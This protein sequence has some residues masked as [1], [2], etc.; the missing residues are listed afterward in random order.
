MGLPIQLKSLGYLNEIF[1]P[2]ETKDWKVFEYR[3]SSKSTVS[4]QGQGVEENK[5]KIKEAFLSWY[6]PCGYMSEAMDKKD[7]NNNFVLV[8]DRWLSCD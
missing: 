5:E 3:D 7:S 6:P 2:E 1:T 4:M 8:L